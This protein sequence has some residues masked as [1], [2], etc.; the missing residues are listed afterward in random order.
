MYVC[1][2]VCVNVCVRTAHTHAGGFCPWQHASRTELLMKHPVYKY[3]IY[4]ISMNVKLLFYRAQCKKEALLSASYVCIS[5][6]TDQQ[7]EHFSS[8]LRYSVYVLIKKRKEI[9]GLVERWQRKEKALLFVPPGLCDLA[10]SQIHAN[11]RISI[12]RWKLHIFSQKLRISALFNLKSPQ[13]LRIWVIFVHHNH[14]K[15]LQ[16]PGGI[17]FFRKSH[18]KLKTN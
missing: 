15:P 11:W 16:D 6:T 13:F 9:P 4:M 2:C 8:F 1:E 18:W 17:T 12:A 3:N 10:F 7:H 5:I 14:N